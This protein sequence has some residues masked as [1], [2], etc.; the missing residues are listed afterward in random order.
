M[1]YDATPQERPNPRRDRIALLAIALTCWAATAPESAGAM[2]AGNRVSPLGVNIVK[3]PAAATRSRSATFTWRTTGTVLRTLCKI[4]RRTWHRCRGKRALFTGLSAAKH[5]F[6]VRVYGRSGRYVTRGYSW[7]IDLTVPSDPTSVAGGSLAWTAATRTLTASGASDGQSGLRGYQYRTS[8][9]G[10][11]LWTPAQIKNNV[12]FSSGG[13]RVVQF[14]ALDRAGNVSSWVPA[15]AG[16]A[17]T[18]RIDHGIPTA[19]SVAGGSPAWQD[20]PQLDLTASGSTDALSGVDHYLQQSSVDGGS[21]W[22]VPVSAPS[23]AITA[24][25]ETLVRFRAVDV[26]GNLSLWSTATA[27]IDRTVPSD[28]VVSGATAGWLSAASRLVSASGAGDAPGSGIDHYQ[29]ESRLDGGAW[30]ATATG[31]SLAV[32]AEGVSDV[33]FRAVDGI[34]KTSAWV[35]ATVQLDRTAPTPPTLSGGSATWQNVAGVSIT[36]AGSSD[37]GAGMTGYQYQ[38]STNGGTTWSASVPGALAAITTEGDTR[39]RFR[40]LDGAGN[41]SPWV[42]DIARI[43]RTSPSA[44][45]VTGGSASWQN[46]ASLT[47]TGAGSGDSGGSGVAGYEHRSSTD[48]G[49]TWSAPAAG[50]SETVTAEG[51]TLVQ[52][53]SLDWVGNASA[54]APG[55]VTGASTARIDRALPS[56]PA[57]D[58]GSTSWQS[59]ASVTVSASGSSDS[60]SGLSGYEYRTSTNGGGVWSAAVAGDALTVTAQKET[61]VQFRSVDYAGFHSAWTPA[62]PSAGSTVRLDRTAPTAPSLSGGGP[63]WLNVPSI[64]ITAAGSSDT[65]G[66]GPPSYEQRTSADGGATWSATAAGGSIDV[67]AEGELLVQMRAVDGAGNASAW[68]QRLARIDW[69]PPTAPSVNGGSLSWQNVASVTISASGSSDTGSGLAGYQYRTSAD[70]GITW[71]TASS[72]ASLVVSDEGYV[73]VQFRSVDVAG[74]VSAWTPAAPADASTVRIDRLAPTA[75]TVTGGSIAW[76]SLASVTVTASG[77]SDAGSG[78]AG[79]RYQTSTDGGASWSV[80]TNG[81]SLLVSAQGETLVR[82]QAYDQI[83]LSSDWTQ[84][85]V[86]LDRTLPSVPTVGGGSL[87]WQASAVTITASGGSDSGGSGLAGHRYRTSIN[88][89]GTWSA[90]VAG[91]SAVIAAQGTTIVQFRS[92]DGAGNVSAWVPAVA[93][94]TNTAKVDMTAPSLPTVTGGSASCAKKRTIKANGSSDALSGL[95]RYEYRVS[96]NGGTS[97]GATTSGSQ[98]RLTAPGNYVVQFRAVDNASNFSAFAPAASGPANSACIR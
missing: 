97:W 69:A 92:A 86:R 57:V 45:T 19:P 81:T 63:A 20:V 65:G 21:T 28:P 6:W 98:V 82:F 30:S 84:A 90:P 76:Q 16:A 50:A 79:Y 68:V 78:V 42:V 58:G 36:A 64:T 24:E 44:P 87:S 60:G 38:T 62:A 96:S 15:V 72:A 70:G 25:G 49:S 3:K 10:G 95:L 94:G 33:R 39:V 1:S 34:G 77:S 12:V 67:S 89:G 26:V 9:D 32:T 18:V 47:I 2:P 29:V 5:T 71:S 27:R 88:G 13:E 55:S 74:S 14:R 52:V 56:A 93:G 37:A 7:R 66:S 61:L 80:S 11:I 40:A 23:A 73:V 4:D 31:A 41:A 48:G 43:D 17:S 83:A 54:W 35:Q 59:A 91:S 53:R 75:P 22:S 51:R 85:T 46:V 8:S